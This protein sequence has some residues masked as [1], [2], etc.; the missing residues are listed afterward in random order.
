MRCQRPKRAFSISTLRIFE[1]N[2]Q[3]GG[4]V[5]ALNGLFPFLPEETNKE[6]EVGQPMCQRP[7]RAFSI[8]T[9]NNV[10]IKIKRQG[11]STP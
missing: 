7:K 6:E 3:Y 10:H 2:I 9:M 1:R 5:N 4:C 8:S 11:V